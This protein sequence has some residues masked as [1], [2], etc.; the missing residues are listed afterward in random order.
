MAPIKDPIY[1]WLALVNWILSVGI[2]I[3]AATMVHTLL[4]DP[5]FRAALASWGTLKELFVIAGAGAVA[6]LFFLLLNRTVGS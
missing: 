5:A 3:L 6:T 2:I 1:D 4:T